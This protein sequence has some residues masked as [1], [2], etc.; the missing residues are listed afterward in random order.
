MLNEAPDDLPQLV[1][2]ETDFFDLDTLELLGRKQVKAGQNCRD[3]LRSDGRNGD[4]RNAP[5][6][7]RDE[8][9]VKHDVR[10]GA[11]DEIDKWAA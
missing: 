4:A 2:M 10:A 8:E 11:D 9:Q 3:E 5:L 6:E 1:H 7:Q